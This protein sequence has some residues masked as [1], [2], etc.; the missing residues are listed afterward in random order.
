MD[1]C[2]VSGGPGLDV[3]TVNVRT[4][5]AM[6]VPGRG[7]GL[8][9]DADEALPRNDGPRL[10]A[11]P[12]AKRA[13]TLGDKSPHTPERGRGCEVAQGSPRRG[14]LYS[15]SSQTEAGLGPE[16][17]DAGCGDHTHHPARKARRFL[18][19][20]RGGSWRGRG[21]V[22]G[23]GEGRFLAREASA[24]QRPPSAACAPS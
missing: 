8:D 2:A 20:E 7:P 19:R 15:K 4:Q 5:E 14:P 18:V 22:L 23:E 9:V 21:A 24:S 10:S 1:C 17:R 13:K 16:L 12:T 6:Q 3:A 11:P